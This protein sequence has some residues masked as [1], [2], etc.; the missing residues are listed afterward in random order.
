MNELKKYFRLGNDGYYY[1]TKSGKKYTAQ[2][3]AKWLREN[4][5]GNYNAQSFAREFD[6]Q[7]PQ[8]QQ[9]SNNFFSTIG[10]G[11]SGYIKDFFTYQGNGNAF[12]KLTTPGQLYMMGKNM[13][14]ASQQEEQPQ[15]QQQTQQRVQTTRTPRPNT[16]FSTDRFDFE[17]HP[18]EA[19]RK[20]YNGS[21]AAPAT[22]SPAVTTTDGT[23]ATP[24]V[25]NEWETKYNDLNTKYEQVLKELQELKNPTK[26]TETTEQ[27]EP[28]TY[29]QILAQN[30]NT[31]GNRIKNSA[32]RGEVK[33]ALN[34][35][36]Q[37]TD[38]YNNGQGSKV[39][40][41]ELPDGTVVDYNYLADNGLLNR[42]GLLKAG[43][44][45]KI[46]RNYKNAGIE[47]ARQRMLGSL[48]SEINTINGGNPVIPFVNNQ[49]IQMDPILRPQQPENT[50][51]ED[52]KMPIEYLTSTY[53]K[54]NLRYVNDGTI[55]NPIFNKN[56]LY[57]LNSSNPIL[58]NQIS[59]DD[60]ANIERTKRMYVDND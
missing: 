22:E 40:D 54:S 50:G 5:I 16:G 55:E 15:Q 14:E 29:K 48:G 3:A 58:Q 1:G 36:L 21:P 19:A 10:R 27:Q 59:I 46:A 28:V 37:S 57:T 17:E 52:I 49:I 53:G 45:R 47:I 18:M 39:F 6:R 51:E 8:Q 23:L 30:N 60:I 9:S 42:K 34:Q 2:D 41:F 43:A 26:P 25:S 35:A 20:R 56:P 31:I 24:T 33:D 11:L 44:M 38:Y 4:H 32:F 12:M 7:N 13:Y